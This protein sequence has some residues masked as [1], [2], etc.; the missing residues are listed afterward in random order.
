MNI[1]PIKNKK[2]YKAARQRI[3]K[4]MNAKQ[5]TTAGDELDVLTTLVDAYEARHFPIISDYLLKHA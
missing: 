1:K 5:G 2:D 3:E 4:L